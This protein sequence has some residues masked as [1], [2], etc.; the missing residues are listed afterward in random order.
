MLKQLILKDSEEVLKIVR[1]YA[2]VYF[3]K[4]VFVFILILVDFF[5]MFW[6]LNKGWWGSLIFI[7]VLFIAVFLGVRWYIIWHYNVFVITNKRVIDIYQ[8]GIFSRDVSE[9]MLS[10]V[11]DVSYQR[12]G[13]LQTIF[14]YGNIYLQVAGNEIKLVIAKI[15]NP[16]ETQR[17]L[18]DYVQ[19]SEEEEVFDDGVKENEKID[20]DKILDEL[21]KD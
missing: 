19:E 3:W 4:A 13:I 1:Q 7:L 11:L 20:K 16:Q 14:K 5:F 17:I 10:K 9:I 21:Y 15:K 8:K 18:S 12:K 6:L 2:L